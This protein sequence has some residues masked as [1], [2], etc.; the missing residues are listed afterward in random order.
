MPNDA[1]TRGPRAVPGPRRS[2]SVLA[3]AAD[4]YLPRTYDYPLLVRLAPDENGIHPSHEDDD[5][6]DSYTDARITVAG[7][8][9]GK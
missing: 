8:L 1:R 5:R 9:V 7:I 2:P 6:F 4:A 3:I